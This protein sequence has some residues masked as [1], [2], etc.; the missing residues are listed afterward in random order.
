MSD[1]AQCEIASAN[2]LR[3]EQEE[4]DMASAAQLIAHQDNTP[5]SPEVGEKRRAQSES[6]NDTETDPKKG[7]HTST[8]GGSAES[9]SIEATKRQRDE[10]N[11]PETQ[12][13]PKQKGGSKPNPLQLTVPSEAADAPQWTLAAEL[14][15]R[16]D[17][18]KEKVKEIAKAKRPRPLVFMLGLTGAGKSTL[19]NW[20]NDIDQEKWVDEG[21]NKIRVKGEQEGAAKIGDGRVSQTR[22]M[23]ASTR[24]AKEDDGGRD[25]SDPLFLSDTQGMADA[26]GVKYDIVNFISFTTLSQ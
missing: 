19:I 20:V 13:P 7:S 2:M 6:R 25:K 5:P 14:T 24:A 1:S 26:A 9:E 4:E 15:T 8:D 21:A 23:T 16:A 18:A 12:P 11:S 3:I 17:A 22:F 10:L